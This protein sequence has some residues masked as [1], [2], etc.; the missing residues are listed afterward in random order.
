MPRDRPCSSASSPSA[1]AVLDNLRGD[2]P[3]KLG[4]T[5][6]RLKEVNPKIVCTHL[7]AYGR[8]GSRTAWPGYD[9]LM[10]AETGHLS[11]TGEPDGPPTRYGLSIVDLMT[12]LVA[13]FGLLAGVTKARET[14]IGM[15]V[16]TSLF[17]VALHNLNY[18]GTW[19]L[20]GGTVTGRT[21]RSGHPS[22]VPS[23]LYRTQDGW[24]FIMC[25]KAKFWPLLAKEL[26]HPEWIDDPELASFAARLA[27]RD[28][29]T[30]LLDDALMQK[31]TAAWIEQLAGKVPVS[32]VF[33]VAQ[34]L[35]NPF[36][37]ERD[38]VLGYDYPDGRAARMI[39]NP[40]RVP[41][42]EL[43]TRAAP[44]MGEH[45]DSLLREAGFD[46]AAIA[47]LRALGV[48]D[49]PFGG[50]ARDRR[51]RRPRR[52]PLR[53]RGDAFLGGAQR[54]AGHSC[55]SRRRLRPPRSRRR[56]PRRACSPSSASGRSRSAS[57]S[58]SST[59][60]RCSRASGARPGSPALGPI[61]TSQWSLAACAAGVLLVGVPNVFVAA[62]GRA[63]D[64]RRLRPDHAG[65]LGDAG[66][67]HAARALRAGVLDQADRRAARRRAG[68]PDGAER[69]RAVRRGLGDGAGRGARPARHRPRR[70][71]APRPRCA[72]RSRGAAAP[73]APA[74]C[75]RS[76]S[77]STTRC[78]AS[79]RSARWCSRR[80]R[81]A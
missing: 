6:A 79:W 59:S 2:L 81:S 46:D 3:P 34:A 76:A 43:P 48:I 26:G 33:D 39:A 30:R 15:D 74:C 18:P 73:T 12:G 25:N 19:Y 4:L 65:Q 14:G 11:L 37:H 20:N 10:Q 63:A 56:S 57:T 17:D 71:A 27:H 42:L 8:V 13:A 67:H 32:P 62:I 58:R 61:F 24:L 64:R 72:S 70:I 51:G 45:T 35:E 60:A 41:G 16:D 9:Y 5:Y 21:A 22:L 31:P 29:V 44:R 52:R 78:C 68:R 69:A 36:V 50:A 54:A 1:D 47:K 23:Q 38:S 7:S 49:A 66:A 75:G 40:I 53:R 55:W 77:C 28:R 80:C